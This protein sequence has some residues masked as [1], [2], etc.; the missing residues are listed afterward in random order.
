MTPTPRRGPGRSTTPASRRPAAV[1]PE[2]AA[3][4]LSVS[5][6]PPATDA[7]YERCLDGYRSAPDPQEQLRYL[8]A[9]AEFPDAG[10]DGRARSTFVL[11]ADV[12]TQN[13]PFVLGRCIANRDHGATAWRSVREHWTEANDRF[14]DNAIVRMVDR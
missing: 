13:A 10:A 12:K 1:D 8:Y 14:P 2:V 7:D 6:P 4:A 9:L 3:G 5:W 11:R